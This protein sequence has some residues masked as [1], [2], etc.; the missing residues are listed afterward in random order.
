MAEALSS[1]PVDAVHIGGAVASRR[2]LATI[3][4]DRPDWASVLEG[5]RPRQ[6]NLDEVDPGVP[7]HGW[8]FFAAQAVE[9]RY[10]TDVVWPRLST[11]EQALFRSQSGPMSGLPFSSVPSSPPTRFAPQLFRVLLLR[12]LWLALPFSSR[13]C[14]C[15]RPLD[16]LGH[17]RAA[18]SRAGVLGSRG[19]SLESAAARV[20]REA[21]ARVSTNLFVRD[22][23]LPIANHDAR[24]LEVVADGL[25]L[26]GGAQLAIDTTLVSSVQADGRPRPQCARVDGAALSEARRRKQR[27]YPELSGTQGRA[28][29][30]VWEAVGLTKPVLLSVSWPRPKPGQCLGC[31]LVV[32]VRRGNIGGHQCWLVRLLEHLPCPFWTSARRWAQMGTLLPLL[33]LLLR[34]A[35]YRSA[36]RC[37]PGLV[38]QSAGCEDF[39]LSSRVKKKK[40]KELQRRRDQE[41]V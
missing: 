2:Q 31:W 23:D 3:G 4:Y 34:A 18:C 24:R 40:K 36:P 30:V 5:A 10:R 14:R 21:G 25:P 6:P 9:Q 17:H 8:Q 7:T 29:L 19:F 13:T 38:V 11:T 27:T 15:G 37:E 26:F 39:V 12:R 35:T 28:R 32:H 20:C 33:T 1:P 22:L 16:V 41:V